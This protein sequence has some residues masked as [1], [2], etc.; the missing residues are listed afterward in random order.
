MTAI[1]NKTIVEVVER[2]LVKYEKKSF[3]FFEWNVRVST[4][5][6]GRDIYIQTNDQIDK[7]YLNGKELH[8]F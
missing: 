5:K 4:E 7:V 8:E 2:R 1:E 6:L 3:L